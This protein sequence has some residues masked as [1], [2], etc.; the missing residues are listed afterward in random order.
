TGIIM[1]VYLREAVARAGGLAALTKEQLRQVVRDG[2]VQRLRPKLLTECTMV[3]GLAPLFWT[4]GGGAE[5][6]RPM[7]IPVRGGILSAEGGIAL[8]L[9]GLFYWARRSRWERLH[10]VKQASPPAGLPE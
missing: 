1:L 5:V 6:L 3:L 9:P 7:V 4:E 10:L 2:A 8:F